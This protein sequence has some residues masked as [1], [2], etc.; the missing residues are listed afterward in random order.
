LTVLVARYHGDIVPAGPFNWHDINSLVAISCRAIQSVALAARLWAWWRYSGCV[1]VYVCARV[2]LNPC[3]Y[4]R[5]E[6]EISNVLAFDF[7][8]VTLLLQ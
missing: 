1:R 8:S 3:P 6:C 5:L 4:I 2:R 7:G